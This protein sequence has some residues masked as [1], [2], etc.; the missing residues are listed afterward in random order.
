MERGNDGFAAQILASYRDPRGVVER[1][2]ASAPREDRL[3]AILMGAAVLIFL[4]QWPAARRAAEL[5]PS[6]PLQGRLS[7]AM[8]ATM[9]ILPL[10]AYA[11]AGASH[12][13]SRLAGGRGSG[14]DARLALF[15]ALLCV[16]PLALVQGLVTGLAGSGGVSVFTGAVV[17][18]V[19]LWVWLAGLWVAEFRTG[20]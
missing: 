12:L 14:Y 1:M 16:A 6:I 17:F 5:D 11:L 8:M 3:L 18:A 19:F 4:A 20:A 7:G 2:L 15:W 9:F 13:V 10:G